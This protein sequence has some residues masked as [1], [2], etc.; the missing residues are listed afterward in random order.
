MI[1]RGLG[2]EDCITMF[3][4]SEESRTRNHGFKLKE[5]YNEFLFVNHILT[6]ESSPIGC[7]LKR[8]RGVV[9]KPTQSG[10]SQIKEV[11]A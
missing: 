8:L 5:F 4:L 3:Q 10:H 6:V 1:L 11:S 7:R 2:N 9:H